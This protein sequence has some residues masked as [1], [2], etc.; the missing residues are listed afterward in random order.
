MIIGR[1]HNLL[2]D[3]KQ[4]SFAWTEIHDIG[5]IV[6]ITVDIWLISFF[7]YTGISSATDRRVG[8]GCV[9]KNDSHYKE[10]QYVCIVHSKYFA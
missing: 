6:L 8:V 7:I 1:D 10:S 9:G 5:I 4:F 2:V 3:M